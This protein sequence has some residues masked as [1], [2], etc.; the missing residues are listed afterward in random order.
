MP[1]INKQMIS[2]FLTT[3]CNL[4][5]E[6][7]YNIEQREKLEEKTLSFEIA[8][9][10][11]DLHFSNGGKEHIRFYGPGEP[12]EEFQLL[13]K[14]TEYAKKIAKKPITFEMQTNGCFS[15]EV[16]EW[17]LEN[18]NILWLSF[19]GEPDI[20]NT[21]R[22]FPDNSPTS[23]VI[24][25][26]VKYFLE[27]RKNRDLMVGARVTITKI[28]VNR[29]K[30]IVDY[31]NSIG[32]NYIWTDPIFHTVDDIPVS[33][34]KDK[35]ASYDFDMDSYV[36]N[37]LE[38][39]R[40]AKTKNIFYGS[41]FTCN[42]DGKCTQHC[43]SC[44]P[45]M[46]FTP[47]GYISACDMVTFGEDSHHM[48]CFVYGKWDASK[49]KF[50]FDDKKIK[51]LQE[52]NIENMEHCKNCFAAEH[53]GGYCLGEVVNETG[54]LDGQKKIACKAIRRLYAELGEAEAPYPY[55]HP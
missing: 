2:F 11:I 50:E 27:N 18:A 44:I 35:Q 51:A 17:L 29:Q 28:N 41:I 7:C 39:Y 14:I 4:C 46:H 19:D 48:D 45:A 21:N 32:I 30:Q 9:A 5:C 47:D 54:R 40:Y 43:R 38:A 20:Q 13:K 37:Y 49:Q 1:H 52:R 26:N 42:F 25:S 22:H 16:R 8:K 23:E 53:C 15:K 24:E 12:T 10:G 3:K 33:E 6:Y 31:F 55:L 34:D 36:E